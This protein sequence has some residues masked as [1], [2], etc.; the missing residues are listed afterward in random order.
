MVQVCATGGL[1]VSGAT[2]AC[3]VTGVTFTPTS[4]VAG[5]S[6]TANVAIKNNGTGSQPAGWRVRLTITDPNGG[7]TTTTSNAY[8]VALSGGTQTA[9]NVTFTVPAS[10]PAG[11]HQVCAEF[12][13]A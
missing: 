13:A 10:N 6:C 3:T 2:P 12:L 4:I 9:V 1:A 7:V 5:S 8:S 11:N